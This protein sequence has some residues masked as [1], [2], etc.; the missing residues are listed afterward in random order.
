MLANPL[1]PEMVPPTQPV[2]V[3]PGAIW[4]PNACNDHGMFASESGGAG[5]VQRSNISMFV[6]WMLQ[7]SQ[8]LS[9]SPIGAVNGSR[10]NRQEN[11][12]TRIAAFMLDL[13]ST[14]P[15]QRVV[16]TIRSPGCRP[17]KGRQSSRGRMNP[18]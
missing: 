10:P 2:L 1:D 14:A 16:G 3:Q 15:Q 12:R 5:K 7:N 11:V 18:L 8:I 9:E 6:F 17:H 13:S 4:V